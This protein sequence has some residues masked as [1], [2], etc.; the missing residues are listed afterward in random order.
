ML[1]GLIGLDNV[2][3]QVRT[4]VNLTQLAQRSAQLGMSAPPMSRH[5]VF[6]GPPGT[7]KTTVARLYGTILAELG[8]LR[9]GHLVEASRADLVAQI[10]GGTAIKTTE[11]FTRGAGRGA[12]RGRGVHPAVRRPRLRRGLP[13][14]DRGHPAELME[15][16]RDDITVVA[17]GYSAEM[18]ALLSSNPGLSSRFSRIVEFEDCSVP[19]LVAIMESMCVQHQYELDDTTRKALAVHFERIP[20][21]TGFGNGRAARRV[22]EEMVDRQMF[23]PATQPDVTERDLTLPV[24]EDLGEEAALPDEAGA[25]GKSPPAARGRRPR[26]SRLR[27]APRP[28]PGLR[29]RPVPPRPRSWVSRSGAT[30]P[31]VAST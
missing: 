12:V 19:E 5:L 9:S 20:K 4:L 21:D 25:G 7:G 31:A 18:E 24:P 17:A 3:H 30:P 28:P 8:A 6:A 15:D 1:D 13:A 27:P 2:K 10:V 22:F 29:A 16:H 26:T 14:G 11:T 23:R